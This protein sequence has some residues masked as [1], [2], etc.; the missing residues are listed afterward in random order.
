MEDHVILSERLEEQ[1]KA[2]EWAKAEQKRI[3]KE[4]G[5]RISKELMETMT[6]FILKQRKGK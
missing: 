4:K 2:V 1:L 3:L 5:E 6:P